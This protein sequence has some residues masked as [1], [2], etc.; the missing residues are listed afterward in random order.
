MMFDIKTLLV[1]S[2][3]STLICWLAIT[4]LWLQNRKRFQGLFFLAWDY[5]FQVLALPLI[6]MRGDAPYW[7]SALLSN[8]LVIS[9]ALLGYIG[10]ERYFE[11]TSSQLHNYSLLAV[12][13]CLHSY[14]TFIQPDQELRNV[15]FSTFL[16][17]FCAQCAWLIFARV[18]PHERRMAL[19]VGYVFCGYC[20]VS[21]VRIGEFF[22]APHPPY[23]FFHSPPAEAFVL[24]FYLLLLTALAFGLESMVNSRLLRGLQIQEAKF[25]KA[26]QSSPYALL[27]TRLTDGR[28]CEVN[29]Q[30]LKLSGYQRTEVIGRTTAE[31]DLWNSASAR[32]ELVTLLPVK[33]SIRDVEYLFNRKSGDQIIGSL[34]A[35][36]LI[37]DNEYFILSSVEDITSRK[38]AEEALQKSET[39]FRS[40]FEMPLVGIAIT[41]RDKE[42][43]K[44]NDRTLAILGYSWQ[45][46]Q[47]MTWDK[48]TYPADLHVDT[49]HF[50]RV[51]AGEI[52]QYSMEKRFIRKDGS[53]VFVELEVG[54][55]RNAG[56]GVE[57]FIAVLD[58]ISA[59][60]SAEEALKRSEKRLSRAQELA[61]L[62]SWE[63]DFLS[64]KIFWSDETYRIFGFAPQEMEVTHELI[65]QMV[66]PDDAEKLQPALKDLRKGFA[67]YDIEYRIVRRDGT[68]RYVHSQRDVSVHEEGAG[69]VFGTVQDITE[70]KCSEEERDQLQMRVRRAEKME[71]LGYMAGKVAHD[72][73]NVLGVTMGYAELMRGQ[74]EN[75]SG[76]RK[77]ADCILTSTEKA[78]AIIQDL[79]TMTRRGVAVTEVVDLNRIVRSMIAS[80]ECQKLRD[81]HPSVSVKVTVDESG[82]CIINGSPVHLE[83][84]TYNLILNAMESITGFGEVIVR[85]EIRSLD[86]PL[87]GYEE[88]A[89]GEYAVLTVSDTGTGIKRE[90]RDRIFE[91][92][93]TKKKMGR[94]GTG[95]GL[96][97][98]WGTVKDHNGY[99]DLQSEEDRGSSFTLYFPLSRDA[100]CE[101]QQKPPLDQ[102]LGRGESVLVIDDTPEQR[103]VASAMLVRL[104]YRVTTVS[105]GEEAVAYLNGNKA[106]I[107]ILDMLMEPGMDGL[108]TYREIIKLN[109]HQKAIIVSG[110]TE[111]ERVKGAQAL[112]AGAYVRKPYVMEKL[113]FAIR[114]ELERQ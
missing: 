46:L 101:A 6:I 43:V 105:G 68:V 33:G 51:L 71:A 88:I 77:A 50:S 52:N 102:Y 36:L 42:W 92:F 82:P 53:I 112:G 62:G 75:G 47:T 106:D 4:R 8:T 93:Y 27:L 80:H 12:F 26:F 63:Y 111:T 34:S 83:K 11:R 38:S 65:Q 109:P 10:L 64:G 24:L 5:G 60:K 108:D 20:M 40:Y 39:L 91:P 84:A 15:I 58:D 48:I 37:I 25:S 35:E 1:V 99:I 107:L 74:G 32:E 85:T 98:V 54:C 28:I 13:I 49:K 90:D 113:G 66:H 57:Y 18:D 89:A 61:H 29:D 22:R 14:F 17:G 67:Q 79:L 114:K 30:F 87:R 100:V 23:D 55:V 21:L 94:S 96:P 97:I 3:F 69:K 19:T 86:K 70:R 41:S 45:E 31:L 72:L 78:A 103:E 110:F 44:V 56:G 9:G 104:N 7:A 16:L 81:A 76:I 73:N 59:R 2:F 95:L